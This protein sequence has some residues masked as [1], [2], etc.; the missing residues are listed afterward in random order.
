VKASAIPAGQ[1]DLAR[2]L[3]AAWVSHQSGMSLQSAY[4]AIRVS[5]VGPSWVALAADLLKTTL[6]KE[7]A[8]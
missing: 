8:R 6:R 1:M 4:A 2:K 5:A 3:Q 7:I